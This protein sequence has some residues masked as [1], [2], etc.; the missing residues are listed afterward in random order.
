MKKG[1]RR[2]EGMED[3]EE[4]QKK[5]RMKSVVLKELRKQSGIY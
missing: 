5:E 4:R 1:K 3:E 2:K